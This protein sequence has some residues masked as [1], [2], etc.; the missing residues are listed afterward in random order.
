LKRSY[1]SHDIEKAVE[2]AGTRGLDDF[3]MQHPQEKRLGAHKKTEKKDHRD[4]SEDRKE[5]P[6]KS[7]FDE[8][9]FGSPYPKTDDTDSLTDQLTTSSLSESESPKLE[10]DLITCDP[11]KEVQ[12]IVRG[13][14]VG[15]YKL[16][17]T[18]FQGDTDT[19][20]TPPLK[21][22]RLRLPEHWRNDAEHRRNNRMNELQQDDDFQYHSAHWDSGNMWALR[23]TH[24]KS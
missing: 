24:K 1:T 22:N 6:K 8:I 20:S 7:I 10:D 14:R 23:M 13:I 2:L 15:K 11:C 16:R 18:A 4:F 21:T 9:M 5:T 19:E 3:M 17:T 12:E